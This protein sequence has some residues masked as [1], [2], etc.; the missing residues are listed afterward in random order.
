MIYAILAVSLATISLA[1]AL[2][3]LRVSQLERERLYLAAQCDSVESANKGLQALVVAKEKHLR[4]L[5]EKL[6][7]DDPGAALDELFRMRKDEDSDPN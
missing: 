4:D 1:L 7:E 3:R 5:H 6:I 2:A